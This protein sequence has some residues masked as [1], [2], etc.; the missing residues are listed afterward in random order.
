MGCLGGMQDKRTFDDVSPEV[1][2]QV[3]TIARDRFGT[4]F[5]PDASS[6]GTATT[7]TPIGQVLLDYDHDANTRQ[8]T[9]TLRKKPM[10]ILSGQIWSGL[11]ETI[12][13]CKHKT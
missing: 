8:I 2:E 1:W 9:Y 4:V 6:C 11:A 10:L 3:K 13:Q 7:A 5:A 12:E